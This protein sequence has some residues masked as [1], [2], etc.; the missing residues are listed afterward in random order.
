MSYF[1]QKNYFNNTYWQL[2]AIPL[3]TENLQTVSK[4]WHLQ[5]QITLHKLA[6]NLIQNPNKIIFS[7]KQHPVYVK[8]EIFTY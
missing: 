7:L 1:V 2:Y 5:H 8:N 3:Y 6:P 4:D